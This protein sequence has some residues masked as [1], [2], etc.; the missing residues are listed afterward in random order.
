MTRLTRQMRRLT[1]RVILC[2]S[3][4]LALVG[5]TAAVPAYRAAAKVRAVEL[6]AVPAATVPAVDHGRAEAV[7]ASAE[8]AAALALET[9]TV[10]AADRAAREAEIRTAAT[11]AWAAA[12]A[13]ADA[14]RDVGAAVGRA[15]DLV[16]R[17]TPAVPTEWVDLTMAARSSHAAETARR[18]RESAARARESAA[19]VARD[20]GQLASRVV[21]LTD[22]ARSAAAAFAG[23]AAGVAGR[24]ADARTEFVRAEAEAERVAVTMAAEAQFERAV[25][26]MTEAV[27][28]TQ[29]A[30]SWPDAIKHVWVLPETQ[31]QF[32]AHKARLAG[33]GFKYD[34]D[35]LTR[36]VA[37]NPVTKVL[38]WTVDANSGATAA[39]LR[40]PLLAV[41]TEILER[42]LV[43]NAARD[44]AAILTGFVVTIR[45]TPPPP[46]GPITEVPSV[47]C[48]PAC[49]PCD[50]C[51]VTSC[52]PARTRCCGGL[53]P[54]LRCR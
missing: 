35:K 49:V 12:V 52:R 33:L 42:Q 7:R 48:P 44:R 2:A 17:T 4:V 3:G 11:R 40:E 41:V 47:P 10:A 37:Y 1:P 28:Q 9:A 20:A 32:K 19:V 27:F 24:A 31:E 22:K 26:A 34:A 30:K 43:E 25:A 29:P 8:R 53:K 38:T 16:A 46:P 36:D 15:A 6:A 54:T 5:A 13:A 50:P 51:A 23:S 18:T 14:G 21:G 39:Q 45:R